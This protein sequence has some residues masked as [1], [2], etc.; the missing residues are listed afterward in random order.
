MQIIIIIQLEKQL[1]F[2][3]MVIRFL[4]Q[5]DTVAYK[6]LRLYSLKESPFS[7]SDSYEDQKN[8]NINDF[9]K[10]IIK[11]DNPLESFAL[12]AFDDKNQL[13]GYVKFK[14]DSRSKARHR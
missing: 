9:Q 14:R 3:N 10:E 11:I 6:E 7:F 5:I 2:L 8:K 4:Q 1:N 12:G 13:I